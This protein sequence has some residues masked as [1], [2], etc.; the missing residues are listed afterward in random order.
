MPGPATPPIRRG[1]PLPWNRPCAGSGW[2][3]ARARRAGSAWCCPIIR[4]PGSSPTPSASTQS[5][6]ASGSSIS[7][8]RPATTFRRGCRHST[9]SRTCATA[10]G[11]RSSTS[12]PIAGCLRRCP[13]P[14]RRASVKPGVRRRTIPRSRTAASA[15]VS[16]ATAGLSPR[17][18][19]TAAGKPTARRCITIRTSRRATPMSPS[20]C[21]CAA[22]RKSTP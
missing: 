2:R 11:A 17:S 16:G 15:C 6:A 13:R 7:C 18:S 3:S 4:P 19:R 1:S 14:R 9:W 5:R 8:A 12:R 22:S 21:G 20:T 10:H